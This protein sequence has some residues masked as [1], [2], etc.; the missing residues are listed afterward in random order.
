MRHLSST[1]R[2]VAESLGDAQVMLT[3]RSLYGWLLVDLISSSS[4]RRRL[5]MQT[6]AE[7]QLT[8]CFSRQREAAAVRPAVV[9]FSVCSATE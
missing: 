6:P 2:A 7:Q 8:A 1:R 9:V 5:T 3:Q 4:R